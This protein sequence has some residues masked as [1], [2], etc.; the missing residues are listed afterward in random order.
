M[1][2]VLAGDWKQG[3]WPFCRKFVVSFWK[4][5]HSGLCPSV[6]PLQCHLY[7]SESRSPVTWQSRTLQSHLFLHMLVSCPAPPYP[8]SFRLPPFSLSRLV[9]QRNWNWKLPGAFQEGVDAYSYIPR[10]SFPLLVQLVWPLQIRSLMER[11]GWWDRL[12]PI[13]PKL[14]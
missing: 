6:F 4:E 10:V 14:G 2:P 3:I 7:S 8:S 1:L 12:V 13:F 5:S 11:L 9:G